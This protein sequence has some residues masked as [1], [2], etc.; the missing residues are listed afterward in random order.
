MSYTFGHRKSAMPRS[1]A[2]N[3]PEI[4]ARISHHHTWRRFYD[5]RYQSCHTGLTSNRRSYLEAFLEII[6]FLEEHGVVDDDLRRGDAQID[7][8]VVHRFSW[9]QK[10]NILNREQRMHHTI[11]CTSLLKAGFPSW[12]W[13]DTWKVPRLSSKSASMDQTFSDLYTRFCTGS[14]ESKYS[15]FL[16]GIAVAFCEEAT[17]DE[18]LTEAR[19]RFSQQIKHFG[20]LYFLLQVVRFSIQ[21]AASS[22]WITSSWR[23]L[24]GRNR[25]RNKGFIIVALRPAPCSHPDKPMKYQTCLG[26][27]NWAS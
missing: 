1:Y 5:V 18:V 12:Y 2:W 10:K 9:L 14:D 24:S 20:T 19:R 21:I 8:A 26:S 17:A 16:D 23:P 11:T 4:R 22:N 3:A 25:T 15:A 13:T 7:D 27:H 6:V